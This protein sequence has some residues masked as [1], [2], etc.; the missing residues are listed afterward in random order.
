MIAD[1]GWQYIHAFG[2]R[3]MLFGTQAGPKTARSRGYQAE[4]ARLDRVLSQW[5][6][7]LSQRVTRSERQM[8]VCAAGPSSAE[9]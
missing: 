1:R 2:F 9:F 3:P 6:L 4:R 8:S 5:G 7:R